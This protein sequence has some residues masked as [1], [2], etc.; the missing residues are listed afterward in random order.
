MNGPFG[1]N[2][3]AA[4]RALNFR[5]VCGEFAA[6]MPYFDRACQP[7]RPRTR[8]RIVECERPAAARVDFRALD[9]VECR[10]AFGGRWCAFD[11][12]LELRA[13]RRERRLLRPTLLR[14][15]RSRG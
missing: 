5:K 14:N 7:E 11:L 1:M 3:M 13:L 10:R 6:G 4:W 9:A 15:N 8:R 12:R 2:A